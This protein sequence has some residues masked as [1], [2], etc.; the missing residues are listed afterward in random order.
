[1]D[2][3]VKESAVFDRTGPEVPVLI[4]DGYLIP[5]LVTNHLQT[6]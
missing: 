1:M 2:L 6:T 5:V 3:S 4:K